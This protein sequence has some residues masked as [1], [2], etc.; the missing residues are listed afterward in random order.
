LKSLNPSPLKKPRV[1]TGKFGNIN[2]VIA[3]LI[4][5]G[6]LRIAS[7]YGVF[8]QTADEPA[9]VATGM[10]WLSQGKY[11]RETKTLAEL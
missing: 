8:W 3:L 7:T 9:H 1:K 10:E 5:V 2:L 6:L 11:T 4:V